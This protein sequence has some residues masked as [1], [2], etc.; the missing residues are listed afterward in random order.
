MLDL[1]GQKQTTKRTIDNP[2]AAALVGK[3]ETTPDGIPA[4]SE[5]INRAGTHHHGARLL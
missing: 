5:M 3:F 2:E 1:F 4:I